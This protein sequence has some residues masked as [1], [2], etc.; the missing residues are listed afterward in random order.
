MLALL[1]AAATP[2]PAAGG[3][4]P[5]YKIKSEAAFL[6]LMADVE[7]GTQTD[8]YAKVAIIDKLADYG[9]PTCCMSNASA[10]H[11]QMLLLLLLLLMMMMMMMMIMMMMMMPPRCAQTS[12]HT[13]GG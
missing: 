9:T 12:R 2:P 10:R 13:C 11:G 7:E 4:E 6:Q 3:K 8:T 1:L 5:S